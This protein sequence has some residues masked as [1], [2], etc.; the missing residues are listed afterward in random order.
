MHHKPKNVEK[1]AQPTQNQ[2]KPLEGPLKTMT[3]DPKTTP[4]PRR[5]HSKPRFHP[6]GFII[7]N[8]KGGGSETRG[9][10]Q[11]SATTVLYHGCF[12]KGDYHYYYYYYYYCYYYYYYY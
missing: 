5:A 12:P 7:I 4:K 3:K 8:S 9:G 2:A 11:I 6:L 1:L 10:W